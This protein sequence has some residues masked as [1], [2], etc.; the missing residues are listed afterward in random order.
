VTSLEPTQANIALILDASGSM[1]ADLEGRTRL[2]V[3]KEALI[4]LSQAIPAESQVSLWVYGHR[5]SKDDQ[6]ASCQ[7]IEE[8]IPRGPIDPG[9]VAQIVNG[10][11]AQGYTPITE[12]L[13]RAASSLP[14]GENQRNMVVLVSDG[15]HGVSSYCLTKGVP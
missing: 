6:A 15:E 7:D 9:Q 2:A 1:M 5:L 13:Q 4:N 12:S 11:N 3:A 14:L 8:V 10:L